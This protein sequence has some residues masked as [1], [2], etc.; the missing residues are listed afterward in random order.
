MYSY[1]FIPE[2]YEELAYYS[3][4]NSTGAE[5]A[6]VFS[7]QEAFGLVTHLNSLSNVEINK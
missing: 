2:V 3:V 5:V 4:R 7:L 6:V 1:K